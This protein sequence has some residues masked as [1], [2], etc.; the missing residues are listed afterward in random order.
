M[1][2]ALF[3]IR[4]LFRF[5]PTEVRCIDLKK[6]AQDRLLLPLL[7]LLSDP[8]TVVCL[9]VSTLLSF[10]H[11][12]D[13]AV[14]CATHH[15]PST[16]AVFVRVS[17]NT[18]R[19][20]LP[21]L[22]Y[23]TCWQVSNSPSWHR[24][25]FSPAAGGCCCDWIETP[26]LYI[27]SGSHHQL[28]LV[29]LNSWSAGK[30]V[31]IKDSEQH[32]EPCCSTVAA[33]S[34]PVSNGLGVDPQTRTLIEH[35]PDHCLLGAFRLVTMMEASSVVL[36]LLLGAIHG[37]SLLLLSHILKIIHSR[38]GISFLFSRPALSSYGFPVFFA[39]P[40]LSADH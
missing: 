1:R 28:S 13:G 34:S 31:N 40:R 11:W 10:S 20:L 24:A 36:I 26:W 16:E 18:K 29:W 5:L 33:T 27:S 12:P 30:V 8:W 17:L 25:T 39:M 2:L 14:L 37:E 32:V 15:I 19:F 9:P 4:L 23:C 7:L 3:P 38:S 22:A 35:A 6:A 21:S